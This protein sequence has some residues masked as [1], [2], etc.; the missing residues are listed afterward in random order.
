MMKSLL[1]VILASLLVGSPTFAAN[2]SQK[3]EEMRIVRVLE[4]LSTAW[5]V[6]DRNAWAGAFT[7]DA[8]FTVLFE[9]GKRGD[10]KIAWGHQLIFDN[11]HADTTFNI[12]IRQVRFIKP[13]VAIVQLNGFVATGDEGGPVDS[14]AI[15]TVILERTSTQWKIV[16]FQNTPFVVDEFRAYGNLRRF[17]PT[18]AANAR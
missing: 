2:S 12:G 14:Y 4:R 10:E 6:G 16:A 8:Y 5:Q 11:F 18:S 9:L 3:R 17:K 1:I 15:P 7:E 13:E